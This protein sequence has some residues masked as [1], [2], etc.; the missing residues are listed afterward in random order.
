MTFSHFKL[1]NI[2]VF[3][4]KFLIQYD[5]ISETIIKYLKIN[6]RHFL[7]SNLVPQHRDSIFVSFTDGKQIFFSYP[8]K[9]MEF[10]S[11][12]S[13]FNLIANLGEQMEN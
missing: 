3:N 2:E 13:H 9:Q 1:F 10:H 6:L 11:W 4:R 12:Q 5:N 8:S 7:N